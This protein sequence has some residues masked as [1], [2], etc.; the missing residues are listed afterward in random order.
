MAELLIEY[1]GI[2][3]IVSEKPLVYARYQAKGRAKEATV[4]YGGQG[5]LTSTT[6]YSR[7]QGQGDSMLKEQEWILT[8]YYNLY[9]IEKKGRMR[10]FRDQKSFIKLYP[11]QVR[12]KLTQ[13]F[14]EKNI[15]FLNVPQIVELCEYAESL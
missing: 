11:K 7:L 14:Q 15:D 3:E 13:Y 12:E 8:D 6:T 5:T 1:N 2:S 4:G 9:W 10:R